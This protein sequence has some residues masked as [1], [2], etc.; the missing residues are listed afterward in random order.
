MNK[1]SIY[2]S[3]T[4][5]YPFIYFFSLII[6]L[7]AFEN[8]C[9]AQ[10]G[11]WLPANSSVT[12]P[13]IL[14]NKSQISNVKENISKG[15]SDLISGVY[16]SALSPI[17][18][19]NSESSARRERARI[20]KNAAFVLLMNYKWVQN[21]TD[22]L[23]TYE[24]DSLKKR[25]LL[26][27]NTL[28]ST[29]P[30]IS[31][32][33]PSNYDDWQWRSKDMIDYL[34][35][36]DL[37]KGANVPDSLLTSAKTNLQKY[38][39]NL[40]R[41]ATRS[42]FGLTFLSTVKNNHALMTCGALGVAAVVL[43]DATSTD[44]NEQPINWINAALWNM[45]NIFW[46]DAARQSDST[47]IA[48]YAEGPYYLRYAML[49]D[50]P[51]ILGMGNFLLDT[52]I[53]TTFNNEERTILNP[54]LDNKYKLLWQWIYKITLPD[55]TL[56]PVGDTYVNTAFPE[57]ELVT[58]PYTTGLHQNSSGTNTYASQLNST[59]DMRANYIAAYSN[60]RIELKEDYLNFLPNSGD[61]VFRSSRDSNAIYMHVCGANGLARTSGA[62]HNQADVSS[63]MFYKGGEP[64]ARDGG[65]ISY[66]RRSEV[67]NASNHNLILVDGNGP[68]IGSPAQPNDA[69]GFIENAMG[70][71]KLHY[72][73]VRTNY[74][75]TDISRSFLFIRKSYF[76]NSDFISSNDEHSYTWQFHSGGKNE[77]LS[78]T[79]NVGYFKSPDFMVGVASPNAN[80]QTPMNFITDSAVHEAA[81]NATGK[82]TVFLGKTS[83]AKKAAILSLIAPIDKTTALSNVMSSE[84][85][86]ATSIVTDS[87]TNR[88][89]FFA[90]QSDT[91][92]IE[93]LTNT[94]ETKTLKTDA[95]LSYWSFAPTNEGIVSAFMREGTELS[96][97]SSVIMKATPRMNLAID[98]TNDTLFTVNASKAG[99]IVL[100]P[101]FPATEITGDSISSFGIEIIK[102]VYTLILKLSAPSKITV[103]LT[104]K[105]LSA[106]EEPENFQPR[107]VKVYPNPTASTLTVFCD[108]TKPGNTLRLVSMVG[109]EQLLF[110]INEPTVTIPL[111][112]LSTGMYQ[113]LLMDHES[114]VSSQKVVVIQ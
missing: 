54:R 48:G 83:P 18:A 46:R 76:I 10:T 27:L 8:C 7:T 92:T 56:P 33:N 30:A 84:V 44:P 106:K 88:R 43:N 67:G 81:Y 39:S 58:I 101:L 14:L 79:N 69:N 20:A 61:L 107:I 59:V 71:P 40:Y 82:H 25:V 21:K 63:F 22:T 29:I 31:I 73:E 95:R 9:F 108:G 45:D 19:D 94:V 57:L 23:S 16:Q 102:G 72:G 6:T 60:L 49:N 103:G 66:V 50:I 13:R 68:V 90:A 97:D 111:N 87:V 100:H 85:D 38:A 24:A 55:G 47:T 104:K 1:F 113:L 15:H 91:T 37:L 93:W 114:V 2:L 4:T 105:T 53:T 74:L 52:S 89:D 65:Y 34:S 51:F 64:I 98:Y 5:S 109:V 11:S 3:K 70:L 86:F 42:F 41:E 80:G 110:E 35:A 36:Y 28:N 17:P 26:L 62:G 77:Q 99:E 112:T 78:S 12:Y 32:T 96:A 75:N